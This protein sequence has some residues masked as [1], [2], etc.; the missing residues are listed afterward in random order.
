LFD[1][2]VDVMN[3][4]T[5][6]GGSDSFVNVIASITNFMAEKS[7]ETK[8]TEEEKEE[9]A[10]QLM[11]EMAAAMG[12]DIDSKSMIGSL[13]MLAQKVEGVLKVEKI[14]DGFAVELPGRLLFPARD[15]E[16]TDKGIAFMNA[17]STILKLWNGNV[18]VVCYW[19]WH[20]ASEVESQII[21]ILI[22]NGV[23]GEH[24]HPKVFPISKRTIRFV[25]RG[26]E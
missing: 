13:K 20:E 8:V 5:E 24:I 25:M 18:D 17:V 10:K 19:A 23:R 21:D 16:M 12:G 7:K 1:S 22:R 11:E 2:A 6:G 26:G 14:D 3:F 9:A 15:I 4:P